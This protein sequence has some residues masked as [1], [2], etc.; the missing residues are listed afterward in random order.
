MTPERIAKLDDA[1]FVWN[2]GEGGKLTKDKQWMTRYEQLKSFKMQYGH[3]R[4]PKQHK[5]FKGK[6]E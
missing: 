3:I 1:G 6:G 4:V 2:P 5:D